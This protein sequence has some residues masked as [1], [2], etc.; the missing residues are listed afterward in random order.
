MYLAV[1]DI[2]Y[3]DNKVGNYPLIN[4]RWVRSDL[5]EVHRR[6]TLQKESKPYAFLRALHNGTMVIGVWDDHDYGLDNGDRT[7]PRH[8]KL[9]MKGELLSFLDERASSE[10]RQRDGAYAAYTYGKGNR[11]VKIILLDNRWFRAS[12]LLISQASQRPL[13]MLGDPGGGPGE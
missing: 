7:A 13:S 9:A 11:L 4:E 8:V 2:V 3:N 12:A 5:S 1:G 10:R 6:Y